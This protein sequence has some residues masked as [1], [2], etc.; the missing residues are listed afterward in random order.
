MNPAT[1]LAPLVT[2]GVLTLYALWQRS[3]LRRMEIGR[4]AHDARIR[5]I[6]AERRR[7]RLEAS[8]EHER[9]IAR[10]LQGE[11]LITEARIA[12]RETAWQQHLRTERATWSEEL[13]RTVRDEALRLIDVHRTEV[14]R[15]LAVNHEHMVAWRDLGVR[16]ALEVSEAHKRAFDL[17]REILQL[18]RDGFAPTPPVGALP[19]DEQLPDVV[20]QAISEVAFSPDIEAHLVAFAWAQLGA[21]V[22]AGDLAVGILRGDEA[23]PR[24]PGAP[25]VKVRVVDGEIV[26][27]IPEGAP[28]TRYRAGEDDV[29]EE[30]GED[31]DDDDDETDAR[32]EAEVRARRRRREVAQEDAGEG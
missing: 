1:M 28:L 14:E 32:M 17:Q 16:Q 3:E 7:E 26:G 13:G 29:E 20:Q 31:L 15:I 21:G 2:T 30:E 11:Q 23:P 9:D 4:D 5:D 24:P 18:K 8:T 10:R 25:R 19:K 27:D 6:E 12:D 22:L